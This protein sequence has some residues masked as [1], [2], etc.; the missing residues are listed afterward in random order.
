MSRPLAKGDFNDGKY[1][2]CFKQGVFYTKCLPF[3]L[4]ADQLEDLTEEYNVQALPTF[5]VFKDGK[6]VETLTGASAEKLAQLVKAHS[7]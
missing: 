1:T 6:K 7:K 2:G 3:Q 4:D 5:L